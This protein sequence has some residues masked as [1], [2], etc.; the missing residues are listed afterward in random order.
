[1][2]LILLSIS[3]GSVYTYSI[4]IPKA[5]KGNDF[6]SLDMFSV[7]AAVIFIFSQVRSFFLLL[8]GDQN[9]FVWLVP[10]CVYLLMIGFYQWIFL[11]ELYPLFLDSL[12]GLILFF[13]GYKVN[14]ESSRR[15]G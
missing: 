13:L 14:K 3:I 8:E 7:F 15:M 11:G 2:I 10:F 12:R 1:M 5:V 4:A 6:F 9:F